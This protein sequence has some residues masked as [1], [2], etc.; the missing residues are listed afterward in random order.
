MKSKNKQLSMRH[1]EEMTKKMKTLKYGRP[2][3]FYSL[4]LSHNTILYARDHHF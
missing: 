3:L 1:L 2:F 4:P